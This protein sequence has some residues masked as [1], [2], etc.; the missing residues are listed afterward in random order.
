MRVIKALV[1]VVA[2]VLSVFPCRAQRLTIQGKGLTI[3]QVL[4]MIQD[5]APY[6]VNCSPEIFQDAP[7][8]NLDCHNCLVKEVLQSCF[9]GLKLGFSIENRRIT[10]Y[11]TTPLVDASIY[12]PIEGKITN[13]DG[14]PL[15]GAS[16]EASGKGV[17]TTRPD[18]RFSVQTWSFQDSLTFTFTGYLTKKVLLN[19]TEFHSIQLTRSTSTLDDIM[20]IAYGKTTEKKS[21]GSVTPVSGNLISM[22]PVGN[23]DAALEGRVPGLDIQLVNGVPGSNYSVLIRGRHSIAQG[24]TPLVVIDGVPLP[25]NNG[26]ISTI[27]T[28]SAQGMRGA[29]PLNGIPPAIISSVEVLK[30]ASATAIYGSHSAN[31]IILYTLNQGAAGPLKCTVDAWTGVTQPVNTSP[32]L[33][34]QQYFNL[35]KEAVVNAGEPVNQN[36]LPELFLWDSTRH[37]DFKKKV[38]GNPGTARNARIEVTGGDTNTVYLLS[39][40][41]H[42]ESAVYPTATGDDRFSV[43]GHLHHQ[44]GNKRLKVD[45]SEL[46]SWES[47]SLP[48]M[49]L[50]FAEYLA[51]NTPALR[52]PGGQLVWSSNG[53]SFDNVYG[54]AN[55]TYQ[56]TIANQFNHLQ[57]GYD[58]L[59]GLSL[60]ASFGYS[61]IHAEENNR[62]TIAGQDPAVSPTGSKYYTGNA[63]HSTLVEGI[64]EYC[65]HMGAGKLSGL[66]GMSLQ[67]QGA[68]WSN[69]YQ[70]G[71]TSDLQLGSGTGA[72]NVT[73]I[74]NENGIAYRYQAFFARVNYDLREEYLFTLASRLD[75]SSRLGPHQ[76][77]GHFWSASGAWIFTARSFFRRW[78]WLSLGKLRASIGTT[79]NDDIAD[80]L[81]AQVYTTTGGRGYQGQQGVFPISFANNKLGWELNYNSELALDL[82]FLRNKLRLSVSAYRD[83][84]T[85]QLLYQHLPYQSGLRGVFT[86][87]P[88]KVINTGI[89][90]SLQGHYAFSKNFRAA[91]FFTLTAPVNRLADLPGLASSIYARSYMPGQSLSEKRGYHYTGV[92]PKT[93]LF[94]FRTVNANGVLDA[95]DVVPAGNTDPRIYGGLQQTFHYKN[96][97]LDIMLIYRVQ[98]GINPLFTFYQQSLPGMQAP[99]M[100]S[101]GPVEWLNR[102]RQPGDHAQLQRMSAQP[103]S[104]ERAAAN[105]YLSS[106]AILV[107]ANFIRL[108]SVSLRYRLPENWLKRYLLR[109]GQLY[110]RGE[111]LLT[112]TPYPVADPETQDPLVLPPVRTIACG[113]QLTF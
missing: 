13:V 60:K 1:F 49:D 19:N 92:D 86:N 55:N 67:E 8:V 87:M 103:D 20:V 75:G 10:I 54:L 107:K 72:S 58:L 74:S 111:N 110:L 70:L 56:A 38:T 3:T 91:S 30:D 65:R 39:G 28:S 62:L 77:F 109:E 32:L 78:P 36:T 52:Q 66:L 79:G 88:A 83:W 93:G 51:P 61:L 24:T 53:L 21:T 113:V 98:K 84:T 35:R 106:D 46:Y 29:S 57:L 14:E 73:V 108:K 89:E 85:N 9:A 82:G 37:T 76:P 42:G 15:N 71:F 16:I 50:T 34:T 97:Q 41:Y 12:C 27:G 45:V 105:N 81:F 48:V 40:N 64:A 100:L 112:L 7:A 17:G 5:Q 44:S 22:E 11:R 101:N 6:V 96:F 69:V 43:F 31:G 99:A 33:S 25:G 2:A 95:T 94:T 26:S 23:V 59:P 47:T 4:E 102:W 90:L 68:S 63:A 104:M 80:N 18:G